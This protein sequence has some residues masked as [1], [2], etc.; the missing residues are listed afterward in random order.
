MNRRTLPFFAIIVLSVLGVVFT[1]SV[2]GFFYFLSSPVE[3]RKANF[4]IANMVNSRTAPVIH[5]FYLRTLKDPDKDKD[6]L[7]DNVAEKLI[8]K[9][10]FKDYDSQKKGISDGKYIYDVYIEAIK[11]NDEITLSMFRKQAELHKGKDASLNEVFRRRGLEMY[12]IYIGS[13]LEL[14]GPLVEAQKSQG[15]VDIT[16]SIKRLEAILTELPNEP[17]VLYGIG[18]AYYKINNYGKALSIYMDIVDNP[19]VKSPLLYADIAAVNKSLANEDLYVQYLERSISEFP[20]ELQQYLTLAGHFEEKNLHDKA[21]EVLNKGLVVEPRYA[22]FY[23][24]LAI[25]AGKKNDIDT[26]FALY[27]KAV[28]YD[29]RYTSG[30]FNLSIIYEEHYRDL[31]NALIEASIAHELEPDSA[32]YIARLVLLHSQLGNSEKF[33]EFEKILLNYNYFDS[34]IYNTF[35]LKHDYNQDTNN[36][37]QSLLKAIKLSPGMDIEQNNLGKIY[38]ERGEF[39]LAELYF[40]KAIETNPLYSTPYHNIGSLYMNRGMRNNYDKNDYIEAKVWFEKALE[41]KETRYDSHLSLGRIYLMLDPV[42][43][44]EYLLLAEKHLL[45]AIELNNKDGLSYEKLGYVYYNLGEF[46]KAKK[47]WEIAKSLGYVSVDMDQRLL[48]IK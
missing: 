41:L 16:E 27:Q 23:N 24:L 18:R 15:M 3:T 34:E 36:E 33:A 35:G 37:E 14:R 1:S 22:A 12:N 2:V 5:S 45:R 28:T 13:L 20:E 8:Y 7:E 29:F 48:E 30:H 40:R 9:T 26:S 32:R 19:A 25:I 42:I 31:K 17:L 38:G 10:N 46:A 47:Q 44:Q 6:G 4:A 11:S 43:N 21:I 39:K